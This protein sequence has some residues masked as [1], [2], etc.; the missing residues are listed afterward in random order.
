M[1]QMQFSQKFFTVMCYHHLKNVFEIRMS[2][3]FSFIEIFGFGVASLM[4]FSLGIFFGWFEVGVLNVNH[5]I[6]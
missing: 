4:F 6:L 5:D 3:H 1:F 2:I